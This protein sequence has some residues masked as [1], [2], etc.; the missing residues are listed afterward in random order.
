MN[1]FESTPKKKTSVGKVIL[2]VV[3]GI[4]GISVLSA[5]FSDDNDVT[6]NEKSSSATISG[7]TG[8][9]QHKWVE[10]ITF[11]G[12]GR[13][14]SESFHLNGNDAKMVYTYKSESPEIGAFGIYVVDKGVDIMHEGGIPE[15]MLSKSVTDEES[16]IQKSSGEYYLDINAAGDWAVK[17]LQKQ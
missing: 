2:Y 17:V 6:A 12:N 15:V 1:Q 9:E 3:L 10:V 11:K 7:N 13:K 16:T 4:L 8:S 5:V 14:K